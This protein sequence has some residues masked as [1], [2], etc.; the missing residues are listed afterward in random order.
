M[1]PSQQHTLVIN[2][3]EAI[4]FL[5]RPYF[6]KALHDRP[7]DPSLSTFGAS[8]LAIVERFY[9]RRKQTFHQT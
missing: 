1:I 6:A 3:C 4:L 8:Y 7:D 5:Q 9:V 2:I